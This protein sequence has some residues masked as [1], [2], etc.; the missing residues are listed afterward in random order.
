MRVYQKSL[1]M[2]LLTA[3]VLTACGCKGKLSEPEMEVLN[4]NY[5]LA[6]DEALEPFYASDT[7]I[8]A[9]VLKK[10]P[11]TMSAPGFGFT[12]EKFIVF[13]LQSGEAEAEYDPK[14]KDVYIYHAMPFEEGIIYAVYTPPEPD[15][16][17]EDSTP[18]Y[19]KFISDEGIQVLD[20]GRCSSKFS[21]PAFAQLSGDVYYLYQIFDGNTECGFG[22]GKADL[23]RPETIVKETDYKLSDPE[24]YS[25]GSDFAVHVDGEHDFLIG[26]ADG[27]YMEYDLPESMSDFAICKDYLFFCTTSDGN[28]WTTRSISLKT[29]EEYAYETETKEPFYRI[30]SMSGDELTCISEHWDMYLLRPGKNFEMVP[31]ESPE[32]EFREAREY[33]RYYPYGERGTLAQLDETKFCRIS[34]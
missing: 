21:M 24:F 25:N 12:T 23:N 3:L 7:K 16:P 4:L 10:E 17:I 33:V 26:N 8:Y 11:D 27:I 15:A 20:S 14:E 28:K 30:A 19:I 22:I 13:D 34:W 9:G 29:G 18:W 1:L 5:E 2:L 6:E 32:K 31:V